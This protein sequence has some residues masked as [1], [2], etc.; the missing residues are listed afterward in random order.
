[1]ATSDLA[2]TITTILV[3]YVGRAVADTCVRATA[4]SLGK[5]SDQLES[6]DLPRLEENIR[7]QLSPVA[8]MATIDN[9]IRQIQLEAA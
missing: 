6:L 5:T 7:R 4:L 2:G 8:P 1:L 3:P 9:I